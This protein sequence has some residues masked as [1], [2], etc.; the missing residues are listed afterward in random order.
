MQQ[1]KVLTAVKDV[2]VGCHICE[3]M[4]SLQHAGVIN[5]SLARVKL[6]RSPEDHSA[7]PIICRHC[8]NAPCKAACPVP[9]AMYLDEKTDALLIN[10]DNCIECLACVDACPFG[11]IQVGPNMEILKCDLCGG[12]PVCA[13]YCSEVPGGRYPLMPS[14]TQSCLQYIDAGKIAK[15]KRERVAKCM[16]VD[17]FSGS[18]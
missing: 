10:E 11:A 12:E 1:K 16:V 17:V 9:D 18:I 15:N 5:P 13:K 2:C 14:S 6:V 7:S 8:K 4:C 3:M